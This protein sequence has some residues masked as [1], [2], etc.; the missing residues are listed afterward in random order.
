MEAVLD[1][2]LWFRESQGIFLFF[3]LFFIFRKFLFNNFLRSSQDVW[4]YLVR[5]LHM[6]PIVIA[7]PLQFCNRRSF[8]HTKK[9]QIWQ[10]NIFLFTSIK[11][12]QFWKTSKIVC[13]RPWPPCPWLDRQNMQMY[14]FLLKVRIC[15]GI[16]KFFDQIYPLALSSIYRW[17]I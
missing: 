11:V 13:T 3:N 15:Q 2:V 5:H 1:G 9:A 10:V 14:V 16:N 17:H 6:V 4:S 12:W 7:F 8:F